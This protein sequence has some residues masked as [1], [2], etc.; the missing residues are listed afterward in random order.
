MNPKSVVV[1]NIK[2]LLAAFLTALALIFVPILY[3]AFVY[4]E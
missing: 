2:E 4:T 1:K 3:I